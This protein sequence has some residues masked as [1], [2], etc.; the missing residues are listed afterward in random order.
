MAVCRGGRGDSPIRGAQIRKR[1]TL[2]VRLRSGM[3]RIDARPV[4][5]LGRHAQAPPDGVGKSMAT[6][7]EIAILEG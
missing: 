2:A 6:T 1:P 3:G 5:L 7:S 4:P